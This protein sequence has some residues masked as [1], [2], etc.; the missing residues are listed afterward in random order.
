[1]DIIISQAIFRMCSDFV[2]WKQTVN[3]I[4]NNTDE[5]YDTDKKR[6]KLKTHNIEM[7]P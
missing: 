3:Y 7:F 2:I 4:I 5:I 1:M 6:I